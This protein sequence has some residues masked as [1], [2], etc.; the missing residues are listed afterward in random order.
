MRYQTENIAVIDFRNPYY[1]VILKTA[2]L[3]ANK[4]WFS[5]TDLNGNYYI[6]KEKSDDRHTEA[7]YVYVHFILELPSVYSAN[8]VYVAGVFNDWSKDEASLMKLNPENGLFEI[9]LLLKQGLYDYCFMTE[10]SETR[11]IDEMEIEGSFYETEN[12]YS[13]FVYF[14]DQFKRYD[15]LTGYLP[16]K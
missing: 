5:K 1:H 12:D 3:R 14:H 10:N 8:M 4:P 6:D 15:R 2:N 16:I 13:I 11:N 7:D 9:T